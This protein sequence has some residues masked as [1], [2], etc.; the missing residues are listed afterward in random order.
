[1]AYKT[2]P[3]G[4]LVAEGITVPGEVN[5]TA[6]VTAV[7][8]NG[9]G[10]LTL[11][12]TRGRSLTFDLSDDTA[13]MDQLL[14]NQVLVGDTV[15][16]GYIGSPSTTLTLLSLSVTATPPVPTTTATTPTTT[17]TTTGTTTT[18]PIQTVT[19]PP[20]QTYSGGTSPAG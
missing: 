11:T 13:L 12:T 3:S 20:A 7:G 8:T 4:M 6:T 10:S 18:S 17:G 19:A 2:T 1:V 14:S 16:I 9:A 15:A 5:A